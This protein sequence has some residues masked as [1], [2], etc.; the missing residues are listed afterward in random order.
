MDVL[1]SN[2]SFSLKRVT[3]MYMV[4]T[5]P[6]YTR[7]NCCPPTLRYDRSAYLHSRRLPLLSPCPTEIDWH[8]EPTRISDAA[9]ERA[10]ETAARPSARITIPVCQA[11]A[12]HSRAQNS[13]LSI[14]LDDNSTHCDDRPRSARACINAAWSIVAKIGQL[15]YFSL[16]PKTDDHFRNN[17]INWDLCALSGTFSRI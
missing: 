10:F 14:N 7:A 15:D 9:L 13:I 3:S 16:N 12:P 5:T 6:A 4:A 11:C 2:F 1:N 8:L 17:L